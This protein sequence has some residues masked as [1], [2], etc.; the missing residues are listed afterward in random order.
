MDITN[1]LKDFMEQINKGKIEVYNEFS[2]QHELGIFLRGNK[3]LKGYK[4]QFERNTKYFNIKENIKHEIDIVIYKEN[5]KHEK[6]SCLAI[7]LK[8]HLNGQYPEQMYSFIKDIK[9]MEELSENGFENTYC[10]TL[11]QDDKYYSVHRKPDDIYAYFRNKEKI[12]G[13]ISKP[14]GNKDETI[15]LN[16]EYSVEWQELSNFEE[17]KYY[18]INIKKQ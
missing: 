13:K 6:S 10:L 15:E 17:M 5:K 7:E 12:A 16:G 11:V 4:I 3:K 1:L 2:L 8:Y 18:I 14:T 9:F